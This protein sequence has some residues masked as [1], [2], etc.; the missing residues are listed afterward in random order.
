MNSEMDNLNCC[1]ENNEA[2]RTRKDQNHRKK[3]QFRGSRLNQKTLV[4]SSLDKDADESDSE[5][6]PGDGNVPLIVEDLVQSTDES[7]TGVKTENSD[8]PITIQDK[9]DIYATSD[10]GQGASSSRAAPSASQDQPSVQ[11]DTWRAID[12]TS[13]PEAL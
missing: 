4:E 1:Q 9:R 11:D 8:V 3:E 6:D 13:C 2:K 5:T 7:E 12:V 10:A